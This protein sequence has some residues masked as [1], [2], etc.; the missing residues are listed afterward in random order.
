MR[1]LPLGWRLAWSPN[2]TI[3]SEVQILGVYLWMSLE[4]YIVVSL[5]NCS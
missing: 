3:S 4:E 2:K 1:V 5:L